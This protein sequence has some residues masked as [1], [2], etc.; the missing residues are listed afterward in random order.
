MQFKNVS[1]IVCMMSACP[2]C[3]NY[4]DVHYLECINLTLNLLPVCVQR[5]APLMFSSILS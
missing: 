2:V 5:L 4:I 3:T 1:A